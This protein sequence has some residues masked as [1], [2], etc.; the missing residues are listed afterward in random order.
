MFVFFSG[1]G[2]GY[3]IGSK[4]AAVMGGWQWALRVT[5]VFG[6]AC[7]LLILFVVKEPVRG[8][9]EGAVH[10]TSE[11]RQSLN[12]LDTFTPSV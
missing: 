12:H 4:V 8:Q 5:P 1:S 6:V 7:A 2:L 9:N 11:V 10:D 3:I